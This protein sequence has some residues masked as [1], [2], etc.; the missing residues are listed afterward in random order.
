VNRTITALFDSRRDAEE[1]RDSLISHGVD[2]GSIDISDQTSMSQGSSGRG[3][4]MWSALKDMFVPD[5]DRRTYEEGIR[6]G[7]AL[8]TVRTDESQV[9]E[10]IAGLDRTKAVDVDS[11]R[12]EWEKSGWRSDSD[13]ALGAQTARQDLSGEERIPIVEEQLRVGKREVT[14]GGARIRSYVV[15]TPVHEQV[16]LREE[17]VRVERRPVDEAVAEP[18]GLFQEREIEVT[19]TSE[20][21]VVAKEARVREEVVVRKEATERVEDID[22]TVRHTEVEVDEDVDDKP[23]RRPRGSAERDTRLRP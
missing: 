14:R 18:N 7:H 11:R 22:D 21:A 10:V 8:L 19:E 20:E 12:Q 9:D 1:A 6:R 4:G 3:K 5:D 15:E 16:R 13:A 23:T 2:K 17:H